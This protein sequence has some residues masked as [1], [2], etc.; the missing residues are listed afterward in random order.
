MLAKFSHYTVHCIISHSSKLYHKPSSIIP[1][2]HSETQEES[3]C[4]SLPS[5]HSASPPSPT[6]GP[7]PFTTFSES[8]SHSQFFPSDWYDDMTPDED[9]YYTFRVSIT[10]FTYMYVHVRI[11][12]VRTCTCKC[13]PTYFL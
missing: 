10:V 3:L 13:N 6:P 2:A 1:L 8:H 4:P 9:G 7:A 11:L 12:C 5:T